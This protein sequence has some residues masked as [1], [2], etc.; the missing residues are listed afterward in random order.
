MNAGIVTSNLNI[1]NL[2]RISVG[3]YFFL[4]FGL[5]FFFFLSFSDSS[6]ALI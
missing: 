4:A 3:N 6:N 1:K 2:H 5:A